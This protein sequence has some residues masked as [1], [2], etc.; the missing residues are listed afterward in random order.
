[1]LQNGGF[2]AT[3]NI[4]VDIWTISKASGNHSVTVDKSTKKESNNSL[5]LV[6]S[7]NDTTSHINQYVNLSN[8]FI[9]RTINISQYIKSNYFKAQSF[10]VT[11]RYFDNKGSEFTKYRDD[12][13]FDIATN[14]DW[15]QLKY[16]LDIPSDNNIK[17]FTIDD[18]IS[19]W[20]GSIWIDDV[21]VEPYT[22]INDISASPSIV[23]LNIGQTQKIAVNTNPSNASYK[24][25][26]IASLDKSIA[27]IDNSKIIKGIKNGVTK[28]EIKQDYQ[29]INLDIPVIVGKSSSISVNQSTKLTTEINK[30]LNGNV[31]SKSITN[32]KLQYSLFINGKNGYANINNDGT[33]SYYPNK[34]FY[35][36][37][38]FTVLIKDSNGGFAIAQYNIT[39]KNTIV[40]PT[41]DNFIVTLNQ[42]G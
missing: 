20:S 40:L 42:R 1:M 41:I 24:D 33:F 29:G 6:S 13:Y 32:S 4:P 15:T 23:S 14:S 27:T 19:E 28:I 3:I 18:G 22:K 37:D 11:I 2:E 26:R 36:N 30:V 5:K 9:G 39:V 17:A 31:Q 34:D 10:M 8:N 16:N 38:S 35:G 21:K 7:K 12:H 25:L